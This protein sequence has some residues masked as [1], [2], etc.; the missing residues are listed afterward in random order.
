MHCNSFCFV[1]LMNWFYGWKAIRCV[2]VW[3]KVKLKL[4]W[5]RTNCR[6]H[7]DVYGEVQ[8]LAHPM[9]SMQKVEATNENVA[10]SFIQPKIKCRLCC[11]FRF[12]LVF[13]LLWLNCLRRAAKRYIAFFAIV[14]L[15]YL[16]RKK[17]APTL[18]RLMHSLFFTFISKSLDYQKSNN[19]WLNFRW[20]H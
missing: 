16:R 6:A 13:S 1:L 5:T 11:A 18:H 19:K 12:A 15:W 4:N 8:P 2:C 10:S 3:R 17:C 9:A 20:D 14:N 7:H